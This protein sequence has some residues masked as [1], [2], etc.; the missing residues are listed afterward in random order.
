VRIVPRHPDG[1]CEVEV[2]HLEPAIENHL[3]AC[4]PDGGGPGRHGLADPVHFGSR[5][6]IHNKPRPADAAPDPL[7]DG[8][9]VDVERSRRLMSAFQSGSIRGRTAAQQLATQQAP[10]H[11][12]NPAP[13]AG[14][15]VDQP[16]DAR[17]RAAQQLARFFQ[18]AAGEER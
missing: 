4:V 11:Q 1:G 2:S 6:P 8:P 12:L 15:N 10:A 5:L 14:P 9:E 16:L 18:R 3:P 7:E 17:K 13:R